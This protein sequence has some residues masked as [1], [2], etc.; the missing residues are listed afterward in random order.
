MWTVSRNVDKRHREFAIMSDE[1]K[2]AS[3]IFGFGSPFTFEQGLTH[4]KQI[5]ASPELYDALKLIL[6]MA[7]GYAASN[8]VGS[9]DKYIADVEALLAKVAG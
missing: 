4:A 9:N 3:V 8:P 5:A 1:G 2:V 6:P 7:K